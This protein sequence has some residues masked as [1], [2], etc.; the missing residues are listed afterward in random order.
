MP[1]S[2]SP[3]KGHFLAWDKEYA[4]LKWGGAAPIRDV[5]AR[6]PAGARVLDAGSGGGRYLGELAGHYAAVGVDVSLIALGKSQEQL[7]RSG[8]TAGHLG[9]SVHL[10]PFKKASFDGILCYGVLQH[11]FREE[12]E[13]AVREFWRVLGPG[14]IV[15]FEAF[16]TEDMRCGGEPAKNSEGDYEGCPEENSFL[17]Q[18]GIIYHYFTKEE[19]MSLFEGFE[20]LELKDVKK[21]KVFRGE[22]YRRH[23]VRGIF[24]KN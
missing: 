14:G 22:V 10:L 16:G 19:L 6:I 23:M 13:A 17:R 3:A 4:H 18:N 15:F 21:E 24:R 2:K 9:A 12:R 5:L 20:V 11:L 8:K 1:G 7:A